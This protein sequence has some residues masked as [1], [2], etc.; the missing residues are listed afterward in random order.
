MARL[1]AAS[2]VSCC[3]LLAPFNRATTRAQLPLLAPLLALLL[4]LLT[5]CHPAAPQHRSASGWSTPRSLRSPPPC[6]CLVTQANAATAATAALVCAGCVYSRHQDALDAAAAAA[7]AAATD[8]YLNP[9]RPQYRLYTMAPLW[10]LPT[11]HP[12][13]LK[14]QAYMRFLRPDQPY[15]ETDATSAALPPPPS[16]SAAIAPF[17]S[18]PRPLPLDLVTTAVPAL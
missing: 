15:F 12:A 14:V 18:A 1:L 2:P 5:A 7:T 16:L 11:Y 17:V 9:V 3:T 8:P 4:A 13:S 10:N 6:V